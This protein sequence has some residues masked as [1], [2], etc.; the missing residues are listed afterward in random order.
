MQFICPGPGLTGMRVSPQIDGRAGY[1][2]AVYFWW[3]E[4][5]SPIKQCPIPADAMKGVANLLMGP[6]G[7]YGKFIQSWPQHLEI[8]LIDFEYPVSTPWELSLMAWI[9]TGA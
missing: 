3:L 2:K 8:G 9:G 7:L 5:V 4:A 6:S 1:V